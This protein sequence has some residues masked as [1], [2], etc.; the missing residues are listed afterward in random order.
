VEF[1]CDRVA[2]MY[3]GQ[4][5]ETAPRT[6]LFDSPRHPYTKALL[7]AAV[8]ADPR[9][10]RARQPILL[11]GDIP[12]PLEPPPG[13]RFHTRCPLHEQSSPRSEEETPELQEVAPGH[14][15][16][17]H[18]VGRVQSDTKVLERAGLLRPVIP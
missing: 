1:V 17:C 5:V 7:S 14:L 13:C 8:V 12:S 2:V 11:E 9:A 4:I 6:E 16:A 10:M 18:L 3:L 15:V